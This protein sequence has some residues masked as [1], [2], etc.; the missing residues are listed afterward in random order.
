MAVALPLVFIVAAI[1]LA[2]TAIVHLMRAHGHSKQ[3]AVVGRATHVCAPLSL[4]G[5]RV[6]T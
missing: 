1:A 4:I 3:G 6:S 2:L 5:R